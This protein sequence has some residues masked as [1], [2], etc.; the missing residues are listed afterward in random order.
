[1]LHAIYFFFFACYFT[2]SYN[3]TFPYSTPDTFVKKSLVR[4]RKIYKIRHL[5]MMMMCNKYNPL[6]PLGQHKTR[7]R[8]GV[9]FFLF[10]SPTVLCFLQIVLWV[11]Q[12]AFQHCY[13]C[14]FAVSELIYWL[15]DWPEDTY[16][17]CVYINCDKCLCCIIFILILYNWTGW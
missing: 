14:S 4:A 8:I 13:V 7:T 2:G 17:D 10:N 6:K 9:K 12:L 15:I 5:G 11:G 16:A 1:M 3:G